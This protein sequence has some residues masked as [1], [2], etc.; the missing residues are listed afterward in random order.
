MYSRKA[1]FKKPDPICTF[2]FWLLFNNNYTIRWYYH[3]FLQPKKIIFYF[4]V[5]KEGFEMCIL[6]TAAEYIL[7]KYGKFY[8]T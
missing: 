7:Y 8:L 2:Q 5:G 1:F 6:N 3:M 4:H